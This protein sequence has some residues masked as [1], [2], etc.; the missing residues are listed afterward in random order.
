M[1]P[2]KNKTIK[3]VET[4]IMRTVRREKP[5]G[6]NLD[7]LKQ[8]LGEICLYKSIEKALDSLVK[9]KKIIQN[10]CDAL[11]DKPLYDVA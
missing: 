8:R 10:G 9:K 2:F 7:F 5:K 6:F 11:L 3:K 4:D 1:H